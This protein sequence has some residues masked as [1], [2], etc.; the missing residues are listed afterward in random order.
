M[1]YVVLARSC[2]PQKFGEVVGQDHVVTTLRNAIRMNRTAH[3]YLF[4][5]PRGTGKTTVARIMA[6]ALNCSERVTEEPCDQCASCREI[7]DGVSIDV[8]EIDG[9]SNRGIDEIRELKENIRFAP[10]SSRYKIY[11]IDEVHML[12]KEAF[13]ALLKTLEEP[14][15]HVIFIFATTE[16]HRV[17]PTILSRCQHFDFKRISIRQITE[18]LT[19]IA[20]KLNITISPRGL[21]LIAQG[22]AGSLRDAQS[23]FDQ[24]ISYAGET[25]EDGDIETVLGITDRRYVSDM[26]QA[27]L[28]GRAGSCLEI[29]NDMY[30]AGEDIRRFY[31]TFT[32]SL[33][34]L[35]T[36]HVSKNDELLAEF[37]EDERGELRRRTE[38]V[39]VEVAGRLLGMLLAGDEDMRRA[40]DPR[41]YFEYLLVKMATLEPVIPVDEMISRLE[42]LESRLRSGRSPVGT[43][44]ASPGTQ[45]KTSMPEEPPPPEEEPV[46]RQGD[47]GEDRLWKLFR[48]RLKQENPILFSKMSGGVF[49]AAGEGIIKIG[50]PRGFVFLD[51]LREPEAREL[52]NR[53]ASECA[54]GD[55]TV[56]IEEM[57]G[58]HEGNGA[59]GNAGGKRPIEELKSE[60]LRH[61]MVQK[62]LDTFEGAEVRDVRIKEKHS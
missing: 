26:L 57:N 11:I 7:R 27:V 35:M 38:T 20:E 30:F 22:G 62:V 36:A 14:P 34:G 50:F 49:L 54:G 59:N 46:D 12:T 10:V 15:P 32:R 3:A 47:A 44:P 17:L 29:V 2:R 6:K 52:M 61:P 48:K 37:T 39:S 43:S 56:H 31:Q 45:E 60:A 51:N 21:A 25:I 42:A 16:I 19:A 18:N 13:N 28:E 1:E 53:V 8:R 41:L 33:M 4:S 55:V 23:L 58:R 24:V 40:S 5:G 9:A